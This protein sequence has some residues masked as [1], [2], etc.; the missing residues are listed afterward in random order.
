MQRPVWADDLPEL[1]PVEQSSELVITD[2]G[3]SGDEY[4]SSFIEDESQQS[5]SSSYSP[6]S[7][8]SEASSSDGSAVLVEVD[9]RLL[10]ARDAVCEIVA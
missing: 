4:E 1:E 8:A 3:E 10:Y 9:A 2:E 6:S 7:E 5:S